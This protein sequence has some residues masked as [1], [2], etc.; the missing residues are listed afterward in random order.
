MR[1]L[2]QALL[3]L[4]AALIPAGLTAAFHPRRPAWSED[5]LLPGEVKLQT[6][7]AWGSDVLWIDARSLKEYEAEHV[8]G[9]I[10]LNLEDWEQLFPRFLDRWR[11]EE[12]IVVYCSS[13]SCELS[14]EVA[15]RLKTNG[16]SPVY[17]LKGGWEAWKNRK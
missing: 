9:A 8:P 4:L 1:A 3:I 6:V 5:T 13:T 16:I 17:V 15:E 12:K 7:L 2:R 10:L 14:H 11:P